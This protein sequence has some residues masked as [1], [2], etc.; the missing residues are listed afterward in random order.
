MV[1]INTITQG[2]KRM[3]NLFDILKQANP[4]SG[5]KPATKNAAP[6]KQQG[7]GPAMTNKP[8]RKAAGRGR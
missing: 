2:N 8:M 7:K 6:Q 3:A 5:S 4:K 1:V